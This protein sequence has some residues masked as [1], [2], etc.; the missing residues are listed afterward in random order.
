MTGRLS[1]LSLCVLFSLPA[2]SGF[3]EFA[4]WI[5]WNFVSQE[6][7]KT[8]IFYSTQ[9]EILPLSIGEFKPRF[10]NI[11]FDLSGVMDEV[12]YSS[13]NLS[14]SG[15]G[16]L[17]I[18]IDSIS[19][20]QM[21]TREFGGNVLEIHVKADCQPIRI[22]VE[23]FNFSGAFSVTG[24]L[25]SLEDILLTI[26][27]GKWSVS[28]VRC[29]G[30]SQLSQEIA[31]S[32]QRYLDAPESLSPMVKA[33]AAPAFDQ[34]MKTRWPQDLESSFGE[35]GMIVLGEY[36]VSGSEEVLLPSELPAGLKSDHPRL[37]FPK[38]GIAAIMKDRL[39]NY[40]PSYYDLR[41]ISAF[42]KL[43]GS[44]LMQFLVWPHLRQFHA[45]TPFVLRTD[46]ASLTLKIEEKNRLW[47]AAVSGKGAIVTVVGGAPIEYLQTEL[48]L[49]VPMSLNLVSG[50]L[51]FRTGKVTA[52]LNHKVSPL[53][54]MLY[55]P[56]GKVPV[57]MI[58]GAVANLTS[59]KEEA[60]VLP[61]IVI[62]SRELV[63]SNMQF[64][65][66]L[67]TMDWL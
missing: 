28:E 19:I 33:W 51:I 37:F 41:S 9:R 16:S 35:S 26:P 23:A 34:W 2:H 59:D 30:I 46:P 63:L 56:E 57:S 67:V 3:V 18:R 42:R 61:S 31:A 1:I 13:G 50:K 52:N 38:E 5:P 49:T 40:I 60:F 8:E 24:R 55:A 7:R 44:R 62:G 10:R 39:K 54:Q 29:S 65:Q 45:S 14:L 27:Q 43:M 48:K 32:I 15:A 36:P 53:Y 66:H 20:D 6:L 4:Q 17:I 58:S 47:T 64:H 22:E 11:R 12:G 21:I 25:P